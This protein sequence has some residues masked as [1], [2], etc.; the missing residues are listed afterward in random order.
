MPTVAVS[1]RRDGQRELRATAERL[2]D[3]LNAKANRSFRKAPATLEPIMAR[4]A[5][6]ATEANCRGVI[7]R[8][9]RE[10]AGTEFAKFLRPET[11]FR[12]S[13]FESYLGERGGDDAGVS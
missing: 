5:D 10:W 7:A 13:K 2:I 9:A 12:R 1:R 8:K 11:L 4:L 6:G 3:F